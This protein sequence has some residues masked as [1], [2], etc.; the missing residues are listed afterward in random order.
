M[1]DATRVVVTTIGSAADA[2]RL[3]GVLVG[4]RLAACVQ[5]VGPVRSVFRWEGAVTVE[6]EWQLVAKTAADRVDALTAR[7]VAEHPYEVPEVVVVPVL[8]G[9]GE[10]LSWVVDETR[11]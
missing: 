8:G 4:A 5:L 7:L 9:H 11:S 10:Y 1:R 3:A 2:E 6:Q